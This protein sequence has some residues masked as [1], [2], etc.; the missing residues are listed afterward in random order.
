MR[1][2]KFRK[3]PGDIKR[4]EVNYTDWLGDDEKLETVTIEGGD[5]ETN[6]QVGAYGLNTE[7][8]EVFLYVSGGEIH[9]DYPVEISV[10]TSRS[11]VKVVTID[12]AVR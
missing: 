10:S 4:Y 9:R 6:F 5:M 3:S 11:Q 1:I 12:F 2:G 7:K 8:T